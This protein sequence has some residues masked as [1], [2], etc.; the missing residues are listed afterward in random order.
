MHVCARKHGLSL[1]ELMAEAFDD[2]LRK[3]GQSPWGVMVTPAWASIV[4]NRGK[5]LLFHDDGKALELRS[6]ARLAAIRSQVLQ[7]RPYA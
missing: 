6:P 7:D 3:Y 4:S 2:V 5:H 1:Q